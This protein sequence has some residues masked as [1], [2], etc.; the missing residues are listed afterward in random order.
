MIGASNGDGI[1]ANRDEPSVL[2]RSP[3]RPRCSARGRERVARRLP[4]A[5]ARV[6]PDRGNGEGAFGEW[7]WRIEEDLKA[8]LDYRVRGDGTAAVWCGLS[9]RH[10]FPH[11][12]TPKALL[13]GLADEITAP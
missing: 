8:P 6:P 7:R 3:G 11:E 13:D 12:P 2:L 4:L 10:D 1:R 5:P 9:S